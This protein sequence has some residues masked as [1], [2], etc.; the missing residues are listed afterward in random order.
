MVLAIFG[1]F[2][3]LKVILWLVD[4]YTLLKFLMVL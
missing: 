3:Y 1:G 4:G 2:S